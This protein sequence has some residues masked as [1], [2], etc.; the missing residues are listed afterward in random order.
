MLIYSPQR[1]NLCVK[2]TLFYWGPPEHRLFA[3]MGKYVLPQWGLKLEL[4]IWCLT[5]CWKKEKSFYMS[6]FHDHTWIFVLSILMRTSWYLFR[7][8]VHSHW[9][10]DC[11][12]RWLIINEKP[13]LMPVLLTYGIFKRPSNSD[14]N[15]NISFWTHKI[16]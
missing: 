14:L 3:N 2:Y 16:H 1:L 12:Y 11:H 15:L 6:S 9:Q 4:V 8:I 10:T 13:I 5:T 7:T